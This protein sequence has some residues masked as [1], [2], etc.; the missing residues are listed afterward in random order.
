MIAPRRA[1][2][3]TAS[4]R[5][6]LPMGDAIRSILGN[7]V[8]LMGIHW[9]ETALCAVYF[10]V[11]ARYLGPARYGQWAYGTAAYGMVMGLTGFGLDS[12]VLLRL[13]R[14]K[15]EGAS[16]VGLT[17][18]LRLALLGLGAAG[19]TVYAIV[20]APSRVS[21]FVLLLLIPAL[22]GRGV[23]LWARTCFLA[24]ERV[25]EYVRIATLLRSGEALC[26]IVYLVAG[27]G[28][29]GV[30][31]LHSLFWVGEAIFS[32]WR[33]RLR[34]VR[35]TLRFGWRPA[36]EV[37]VEGAPLGVAAAGFIWLM[38]AP[39]MLLASTG[40]A[41]AGVGQFA[42]VLSLTMILVGSAQVFSAAAL[43]VMSRVRADNSVPS[44]GR[45]TAI[46]VLAAAVAGAGIMWR[47]GPSL[48]ELV[49][50]Q[51]Y[52]PVGA[53]LPPFLLIGGL[54]L[55]PA[56]YGQILLL[57][58]RRWPVAAANL[59]AGLILVAAFAPAVISWGLNGA[60]LATGGAWL[61]RAALTIGLGE[62]LVP[63]PS[64]APVVQ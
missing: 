48:A 17:L 29:F 39:V 15:R 47:L 24:Y 45:L 33:L 10:A 23:A 20:A 44:Y 38:S 42:I 8:R 37:L 16:L 7:G 58:S 46:V 64:L 40:I 1:L 57:G 55:A 53:L 32:V 62:M 9:L 59:A 11:M 50:G 2:S 36:L 56:G 51:Q 63:R 14:D 61:V 54:A 4:N 3:M 18:S 26:G 28:L 60:V 31:V 27:G 34:L 22:F 41:R 5:A 35:F 30:V 6:T 49:L 43:P 13:G 52:A 19:L 12:L 21:L 25:A